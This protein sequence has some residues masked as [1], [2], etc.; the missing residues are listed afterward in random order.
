MFRPRFNALLFQRKKKDTGFGI[1]HTLGLVPASV[2][3]G[4][5][6]HTL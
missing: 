4:E 6:G 5:V 2:R 1:C 3:G